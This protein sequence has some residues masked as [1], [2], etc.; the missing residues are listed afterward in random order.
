MHRLIYHDR[1]VVSKCR[2]RESFR[3]DRNNKNVFV[4]IV[5]DCGMNV[6]GTMYNYKHPYIYNWAG[7]VGDSSVARFILSFVIV[8]FYIYDYYRRHSPRANF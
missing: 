6:G 8:Y 2:P 3:G 1:L 5:I 7:A 4:I